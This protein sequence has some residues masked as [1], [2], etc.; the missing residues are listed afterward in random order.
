MFRL[1]GSAVIYV[2][3][4]SVAAYKVADGW[5]EYAGKIVAMPSN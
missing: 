5:S 2:L 4:A 3:A 1:S